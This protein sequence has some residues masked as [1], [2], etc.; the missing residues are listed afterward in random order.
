MAHATLRGREGERAAL[1][2]YPEVKLERVILKRAST[3]SDT[4]Q[5][6]E[7][8]ETPVRVPLPALAHF[9]GARTER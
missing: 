5:I 3:V 7:Y 6:T 1:W 2:V 4:G 9:I 8:D